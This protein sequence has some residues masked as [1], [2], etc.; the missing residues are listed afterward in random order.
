M[1]YKNRYARPGL[2]YMDVFT[3]EKR[4]WVMSRITAKD[5]KPEMRI[6]SLLH[7]MGY[8]F[9]LHRRDLPG[10]PDIVLPKYRTVVFVH[11]CFWH[12]HKGC[13]NSS[14]PK[15]NTEFWQ[16]KLDKNV[17]R[18]T[19]NVCAL[20]RLGWEVIE[21]WECETKDVDS[22]ADRFTKELSLE[23]KQAAEKA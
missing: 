7:M 13:K 11:G 12:Q 5:T 22:L 6:R 19:Q 16:T 18:D 17:E 20:K 9:R 15:T 21:I 4:S 3:P 23:H 8:R 14:I 1:L 10:T 2:A